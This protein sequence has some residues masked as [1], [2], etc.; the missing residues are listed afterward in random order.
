LYRF[1]AARANGFMAIERLADFRLVE[2]LFP[3][4]DGDFAIILREVV[5]ISAS[6]LTDD[7]AR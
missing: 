7:K 1:G 4:G 2:Y 6:T 3:R 5:R